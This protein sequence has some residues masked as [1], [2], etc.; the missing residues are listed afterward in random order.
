MIGAICQS[1][2]PY[3]TD[4]NFPPTEKFGLQLRRTEACH[5]KISHLFPRTSPAQKNQSAGCQ[6]V[7]STSSHK[8]NEGV[9]EKLL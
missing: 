3:D 8:I 7:H 1:K 5:D 2:P 9:G 6:T 4:V